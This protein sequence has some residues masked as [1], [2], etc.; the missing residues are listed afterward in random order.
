MAA[1]NDLPKDQ[2][3]YFWQLTQSLM[4]DFVK[5]Q[6]EVIRLVEEQQVPVIFFKFEEIIKSPQAALVDLFKFL[7][8]VQDIVGSVLERRI[9]DVIE[10]G[11]SA[12]QTYKMKPPS[13]KYKKATE[14]F[15][16]T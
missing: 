11:H 3:D 5:F 1:E 12:S 13:Q 16:E 10:M 8:G 9:Q 4:I 2:P 6:E 15:T 7:F 14:M